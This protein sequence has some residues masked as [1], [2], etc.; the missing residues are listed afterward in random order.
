MTRPAPPDAPPAEPPR[1]G[2][3][4]PAIPGARHAMGMTVMLEIDSRGIPVR[5]DRTDDPLG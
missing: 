1:P 3:D 4:G 5:K 2:E